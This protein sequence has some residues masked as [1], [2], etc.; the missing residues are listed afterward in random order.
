M[1]SLMPLAIV[2]WGC[3]IKSCCQ[4]QKVLQRN[5]GGDT[6][7]VSELAPRESLWIEKKEVGIEVGEKKGCKR[8]RGYRKEGQGTKKGKARDVDDKETRKWVML[9]SQAPF[10]SFIQI[11]F[12]PNCVCKCL[13]K[14]A[15]A[16]AFLLACTP[17]GQPETQTRRK[18][19]KKE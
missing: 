8:C 9:P 1:N 2:W 18:K 6:F 3:A 4:A 11:S 12:S 19:K 16:S 15:T 7:L 13:W 17:C 5:P 10:S 14:S